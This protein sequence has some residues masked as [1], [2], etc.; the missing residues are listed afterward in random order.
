VYQSIPENT[1]LDMLNAKKSMT[2][3]V[4]NQLSINNNNNTNIG[5][6]EEKN[7]NIKDNDPLDILIPD[8]NKSPN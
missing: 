5:V 1:D 7:E 8:D 4:V 2:I 6:K 3:N